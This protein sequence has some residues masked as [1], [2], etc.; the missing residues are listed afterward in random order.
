MSLGWATIPGERSVAPVPTSLAN[1]GVR[2]P[3]HPAFDVLFGSRASPAAAKAGFRGE[4]KV[5]S[6]QGPEEYAEAY[7]LPAD[8]C[9]DANCR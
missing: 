3:A 7:R 4:K 8:S 2:E 1:G 6:S 9:S 5:V